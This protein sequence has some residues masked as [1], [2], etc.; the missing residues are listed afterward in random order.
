VLIP[1]EYLGHINNLYNTTFW[2]MIQ[3]GG[4]DATTAE[5]EL[6]GSLSSQKHDILF[7][8]YGINYN[9][10]PEMFRKGSVVFREYGLENA[11]KLNGDENRRIKQDSEL[12]QST[13]IP[14]ETVMPSKTQAEK[15]RKARAKARVVVEHVDIIQDE[16]WDKRPWILS[17]KPG[18]PV[19]QEP[20]VK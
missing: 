5:N 12:E 14:E 19:S 3:K 1:G 13:D 6:Q 4:L 8:R 17:G 15:L 20:S 9:N 11:G 7:L 10:E 18:K 16:F 2:A